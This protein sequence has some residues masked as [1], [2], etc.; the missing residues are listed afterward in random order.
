MTNAKTQRSKDARNHWL[1]RYVAAVAAVG[2][3]LLVRLG[4]TA[5]VGEG[6][7]TYITFYPVIMAVALLGGS[8]PGLVATFTTA[9]AVDYWLL[10]PTHSFGI[11]SVVDAVGLAFF[12]A[13]ESS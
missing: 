13:W 11:A 3:G 10:P 7:P 1:V 2:A 9:L 4:L 6:L 12:S 8:G 5:I